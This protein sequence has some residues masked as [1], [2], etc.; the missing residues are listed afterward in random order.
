MAG[1]SI[2]SSLFSTSSLT[3]K[4]SESQSFLEFIASVRTYEE[5]T[6]STRKLNTPPLLDINRRTWRKIDGQSL[7]SIFDLDCKQAGHTNLVHGGVLAALIDDLCA[8]FC[9]SARP[10]LFALT[11]CLEV[12]FLKPSPPGSRYLAKVSKDDSVDMN[13]A[14]IRCDL[15]TPLANGEFTMVAKAKS[16]FLLREELPRLPCNA[17]GYSFEEV[18]VGC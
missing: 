4:V 5:T 2:T 17:T 13:K 1:V 6:S 3:E 8:E 15:W 7:I 10:K 14:W 18:L 9:N 16:L 11:R 12:E